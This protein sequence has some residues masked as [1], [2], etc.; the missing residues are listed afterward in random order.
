MRGCFLYLPVV[1]LIRLPAALL[2]AYVAYAPSRRALFARRYESLLCLSCGMEALGGLLFELG[3]FALLGV[4]VEYPLNVSLL[5]AFFNI[6]VHANGPVRPQWNWPMWVIKAAAQLGLLSL[7]PSLWPRTWAF[8][9]AVWLQQLA[10]AV[11]VLRARRND[12]A[13]RELW[14]A[15]QAR[16]HHRATKKLA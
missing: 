10:S 4:V 7:F 3:A 11:A 16:L 15:E 5:H 14:R 9:S 6:L 8:N 1:L 2:L 13:L 12:A